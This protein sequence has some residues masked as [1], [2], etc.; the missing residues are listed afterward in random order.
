MI[1][2]TNH[3]I[4][5]DGTSQKDRFP[6]ALKEGYIN[7]HELRF[8]DMLSLG[9]DFAG[10]L[11]FYNLD[12]REDGDW[13]TFFS[14]DAM[15]IIADILSMELIKIESEFRNTFLKSSDHGKSHLQRI[16]NYRLALKIDHWTKCL[17]TIDSTAGRILHQTISAV[18]KKKLR[19][20]LQALGKFLDLTVTDGFD[21]IWLP[22]EH[23]E[24]TGPPGYPHRDEQRSAKHFL[25]T[26]FYN[27]FN[28][29]LLFQQKAKAILPSALQSQAHSP[30]TGLYIAFL[31][32]FHKVQEK[33]NLF[34][35][36]HLDFYYHSVLSTHSLKSIPDSAY[37]I[38]NPDLA[39]KMI[40]VPAG[41]AF[42][43]G[44]DENNRDI[45]YT[46]D[47]D[48]LVNSS[49]VEALSTIFLERD[50]L[51]SPENYFNYVTA[52][53][54][55]QIPLRMDTS[56]GS[57]K[58]LVSWP[59]FGA[60]KSAS[61]QNLFEDARLGFA[62]ASPVLLAGEGHREIFITFRIKNQ[63]SGSGKSKADFF[64]A[65]IE[66]ILTKSPPDGYK[67][68]EH[69]R[70]AF[71]SDLFFK[72][73]GNIFNI[74]L[75]TARGWHEVENYQ[76]VSNIVSKN[77]SKNHLEFHIILPPDDPSVVPY[78]AEI[79]G[80][81]YNTPHPIIR[82]MA[83]PQAYLYPYSLF[84]SLTIREI[85]IDV[86]VQGTKEIMAYNNL[87]Q[88]DTSGPFN[89]FGPLPSPGSYFILGNHECALKPVTR[90]EVDVEWG[91]LPAVKGGFKEYYQGY[92]LPFENNVFKVGLAVLNGGRWQPVKA[93]E[94]PRINL[95]ADEAGGIKK[96][97]RLSCQKAVKYAKPM[98]E[99]AE[100]L[101]FG[102]SPRSK[103][104]F[105][106]FTLT[107]PEYAF[108]HRDYPHKLTGVL[109]ANSKLKKAPLF[110]PIPNPPYTPLINAIS[111]NYH[112]ATTVN[113]DKISSTEE[114]LLNEQLFHIHPLGI[115]RLSPLSPAGIT[116]LPRYEADGNLFIG[117]SP[118][119]LSGPL[120][121][122]FHLRE[123]STRD[124]NA[125]VSKYR[126]SCLSSNRW[127][128]LKDR[129]VVS[130][131]TNGFLSSG[132]VTL[133][134]PANI[135]CNN[136]TMPGGMLWLKVAADEHPETPCSIYSVDTNALSATWQPDE[137]S[138]SHLKESLPAGAIKEARIAIP[139]IEKIDQILDST[140]GSAPEDPIHF[141]TRISERLKHKNRATTPWDYERLILNRFPQIFKV[142]CFSNMVDDP[143]S[144]DK[145]GHVLIV[146]IADRPDQPSAN[147]KPMV[148]SLLLEEIE[149]YV[150]SM[151]SPF[152]RIKVRNPAYEK[153]QIRCRVQ[154]VK[155]DVGGYY[156]NQLNQAVNDYLSPWNK[157]GYGIHFGWRVRGYDIKSYIR[158]L[159]YVNSVT[160]FSMLRIAEDDNGY[161][162]LFDTV[163]QKV[164]EIHPVYP[165]SIAIPVRRHYLKLIEQPAVKD[166]EKIGIN[167]LEIGSNFIIP[168]K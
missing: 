67:E 39:G 63:T 126:W 6:A 23:E 3:R 105:F 89:P 48:L 104:G 118:P 113:L 18:V 61:R 40:S 122:F 99:P 159:E 25:K 11:K 147:M 47:N 92:E 150:K 139:G 44:I 127:V 168:G 143:E 1:D 115:E 132:I 59:I 154:L 37:L 146:V 77:C 129:Y 69:T 84:D 95:F 19:I 45:I 103:D 116:M 131:T 97:S 64:Q 90:F 56:P 88:L 29:I 27:F 123:D 31:K 24:E 124:K 74:S 86:D 72:A 136:T 65:Q 141:K 112:A 50:K 125:R 83:N 119:E 107:G 41:T 7:A 70:T 80:D 60:P 75:T 161:F 68:D 30:A 4:I 142:K 91:E 79:H 140:G 167:S 73:F 14:S 55:N 117:I 156:L 46:A 32:L 153:I 87:G 130:D 85:K 164:K 71:M 76:A 157:A 108:G 96:Q 121:L 152:A 82:F 128:R 111:I 162:S 20:D 135:D 144:C 66:K 158:N 42:T 102:Y 28:S 138:L 12:N 53:K 13:T 26:N 110:K 10:I 8:E 9:A 33:A 22:D 137:N 43:A 16:P 81:H 149:E 57:E 93:A 160:D 2:I 109:T 62:L 148:N 5:S 36:K 34:T 155:G 133:N 100:D 145:P 35:T 52:A 120:T 49:R 54:L 21:E 51:S 17:K 106:K 101:E 78:S 166:P 163:A 165:W 38:L 58:E 134:I 98:D 15:V 151:A 114:S 94:Q